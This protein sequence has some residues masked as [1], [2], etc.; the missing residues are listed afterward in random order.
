MLPDD[1]ILSNVFRVTSPSNG[2]LVLRDWDR[3]WNQIETFTAYSAQSSRPAI[4]GVVAAA[5]AQRLRPLTCQKAQDDVSKLEMAAA[6][7][8]KAAADLV[9]L[10]RAAAAMVKEGADAA[11]LRSK[12][13]ARLEAMEA[14]NR[15]TEAM[16]KVMADRRAV[17]EAAEDEAKQK[18]EELLQQPAVAQPPG[19]PPVEQPLHQL[20]SDGGSDAVSGCAAAG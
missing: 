14:V 6:E 18:L 13:A 12:E 11:E 16:Q 9:I 19:E 8:A 10:E 1:G 20:P 15:C 4:Y 7:M 2:K 5:E 17:E 3:V